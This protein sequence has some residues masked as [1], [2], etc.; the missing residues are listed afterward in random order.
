[1][2]NQGRRWF[3]QRKHFKA[4][5]K[6]E[7]VDNDG[8]DLWTLC[9]SCNEALFNEVLAENLKVCHLCGYHFRIVA[10]ER[11]ASLEAALERL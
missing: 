8:P 2:S 10:E 4:K 3:E 5:P 6:A 11:I 1:M 9:P 7:D